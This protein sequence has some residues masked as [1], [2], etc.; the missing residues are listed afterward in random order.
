MIHQ[1][2]VL[3]HVHP[4]AHKSLGNRGVAGTPAVSAMMA[5]YAGGD[6][7]IHA[8]SLPKQEVAPA[9]FVSRGLSI[10]RQPRISVIAVHAPKSPVLS[11]CPAQ[12]RSNVPTMD[13]QSDS[14]MLRANRAPPK[15]EAH[16]AAAPTSTASAAQAPSAPPAPIYVPQREGIMTQI[17]TTAA[18]VAAGHVAGR[19]IS[20][21]FSGGSSEAAPTE[22][23]SISSSSAPMQQFAQP[24][25]SVA[26]QCQEYSRLFLQCMEQNGNQVSTCQDYMDMMK[27]CQQQHA[28]AQ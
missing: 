4:M 9:Q 17:A 3:P 10:R 14:L 24:A 16:T 2:L 13:D 8:C 1:P 15:R 11:L 19:L 26:P 21:M 7:P 25:R 6:D 5:A 27:A 22:Q 20:N 23:S 12:A 18:G 28:A